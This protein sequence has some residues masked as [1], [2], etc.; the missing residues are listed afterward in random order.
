MNW[1]TVSKVILVMIALAAS[2]FLGFGGEA[3]YETFG[4]S[5]PGL[6]ASRIF[7]RRV[8]RDWT[9]ASL[10]EILRIQWLVDWAFWLL[11]MCLAYFLIKR[12]ARSVNKTL[13][14]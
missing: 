2:C 12:L 13:E 3:I 9:W 4:I 11:L 10:G 6:I 7:A 14:K 1:K 5:T 8:A